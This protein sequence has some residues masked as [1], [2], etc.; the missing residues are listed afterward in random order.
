MAVVGHRAWGLSAS[1][2]LLGLLGIIS[3]GDR[4]RSFLFCRSNHG[5]RAGMLGYTQKVASSLLVYSTRIEYLKLKARV[6]S[7][8]LNKN[9]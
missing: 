4:S 7:T 2:A 3:S 8:E 6:E 9:A 1:A 5:A